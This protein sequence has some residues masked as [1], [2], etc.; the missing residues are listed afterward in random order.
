MIRTALASAIF[1]MWTVW[2]IGRM[3]RLT[4]GTCEEWHSGR[5]GRGYAVVAGTAETNITGEKLYLMQTLVRNG[6]GV[7]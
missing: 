4:A 6:E 2:S 7:L 5:L 1:K 3:K